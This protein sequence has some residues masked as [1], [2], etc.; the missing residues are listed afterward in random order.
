[1]LINIRT[2]GGLPNKFRYHIVHVA[3]TAAISLLFLF[4][5][6]LW[7]QG[8]IPAYNTA[9]GFALLLTGCSL[10]GGGMYLRRVLPVVPDKSKSKGKMVTVPP[11]IE[12]EEYFHADDADENDGE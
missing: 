8:T 6:V 2:I 4:P 9:R 3:T 10:L 7:T 1:M 5:Y 12:H 11:D